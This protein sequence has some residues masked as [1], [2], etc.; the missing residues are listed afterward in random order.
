[1]NFLVLLIWVCV[2]LVIIYL[3]TGFID[4]VK[5]RQV[6]RVVAVIAALLYV[7]SAFMPF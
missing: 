4:D 3:L 6:I 7:L 2:F 1:M 5:I